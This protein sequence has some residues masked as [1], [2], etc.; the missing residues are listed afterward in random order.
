[1][2]TFNGST[3]SGNIDVGIY[4][5]GGAKLVSIGSTAQAGTSAYQV[6]DITDTTLYPGQYYMA[7]AMDGTTGTLVRWSPGAQ[8]CRNLAMQQMASAFP[9]PATATFAS[10]ASSY[11]P[12][13]FA[14]RRTTT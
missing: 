4:D 1:M 3:A 10:V 8:E 2:L 14:S 5:L 9:L 12:W 7:V 13:V 6:F 11:I